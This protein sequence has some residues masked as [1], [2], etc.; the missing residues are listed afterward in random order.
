MSNSMIHPKAISVGRAVDLREVTAACNVTYELYGYKTW[1][2]DC[3]KAEDV[4]RKNGLRGFEIDA[5][6]EVMEE[7]FNSWNARR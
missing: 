3:V 6:I 4:C 5:A 2:F 1:L 7:R